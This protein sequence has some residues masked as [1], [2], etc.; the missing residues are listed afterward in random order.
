MPPASGL[1][2]SVESGSAGRV[3]DMRRQRH[4]AAGNDL[5]QYYNAWMQTDKT[6]YGYSTVHDGG[7]GTRRQLWHTTA[8]AAHDG[9]CGTRRQLRHTTAVTAYDGGNGTRRQLRHTT[10]IRAHDGS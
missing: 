9:I 2:S 10:E 1:R 3:R 5:G 8:V 4:L 7:Y 6:G